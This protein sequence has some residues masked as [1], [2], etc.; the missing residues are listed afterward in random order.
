MR[1][2][3]DDNLSYPVL[4]QLEN[5]SSGSGFYLRS[6]NNLYLVT[7]RHVLFE[8][9]DDISGFLLMSKNVRLTSY[10]K[11]ITI[12]KPIIASINLDISNKKGLIKFTP[13]V[14]VVIV[15]IAN[16][17]QIRETNNYHIKPE[18]NFSIV[19]KDSSS[20]LVWVLEER[21]K[22][23]S[24]VMVSNE[25]IL[26]GYPNSLGRRNQIDPMQPL[27]RKGIIAGKNDSNKT[28]ILDC[29]VYY[30]NSGGLVVEVEE[31]GDGGKEF[32][33][34]GVVSEFVPF[35]EKLF[36]LQHKTVNINVEN[37]GYSVVVPIDTIISL[38]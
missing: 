32:Y 36:S 26:F 21:F 34:I 12:K 11:D 9:K 4:I 16:L 7:A 38:L 3:P 33:C 29:P 13:S 22:C 28:I 2:I 8:Y 6:K 19:S 31:T 27:L 23:Y 35:D 24:D 18:E 1:Y 37:S 5:G 17:E 20:L 25:I 15:K 10:P 30:G 14:D